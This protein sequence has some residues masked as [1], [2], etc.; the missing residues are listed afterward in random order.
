MLLL[1]LVVCYERSKA[2]ARSEMK[3]AN[4]RIMTLE[5]KIH[6]GVHI[7]DY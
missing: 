3:G 1:F 7:S 4:L 5:G 2:L 6:S